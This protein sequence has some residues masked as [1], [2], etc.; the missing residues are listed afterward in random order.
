M[1]YKIYQE[2]RKVYSRWPEYKEAVAWLRNYQYGLC[3]IC[4]LPLEDKVHIDHIKS[5]YG[6]GSN[7][8]N[9]MALTHPRCNILKGVGEIL[10]KEEI[11]YRKKLLLKIG[12]GIRFY[13][14]PKH[15]KKQ[16]DAIIFASEYV[17]LTKFAQKH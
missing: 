7:K 17:D 9:N 10:G 6:G 12:E 3:F 4:L 14:L 5:L 2:K 1:D 16:T 8:F 15:T 13:Q 11:S